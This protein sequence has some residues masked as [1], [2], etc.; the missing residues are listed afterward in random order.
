MLKSIVSALAL[1]GLAVTLPDAAI[2]DEAFNVEA[3]V[4]QAKTITARWDDAEWRF[5]S[6]ENRDIFLT[7]PDRYVPE[8]GGY[9]P[10]ALSAGEAKIGTAEHFTLID[11]KLYLN[12]NQATQNSFEINPIGYVAAAKIS[13]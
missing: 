13:F 8:F 1:T 4:V 2:A 3:S 10:V 5:S 11:E 6:A 9:C 12:F 7:D